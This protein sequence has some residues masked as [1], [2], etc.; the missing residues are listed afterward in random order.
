MEVKAPNAPVKII[1]KA[2][3]ELVHRRRVRV[4]AAELARMIH[5]TNKLSLLDVGCGDGTI[6]K[7]V[8]DTVPGLRVTGAEF[9]PRP[10]CAIPC[11]GFDGL[12]LPFPN[13]AFDGCMFVDV[14]HHSSD[15]LAIV[16]DARRVSRDFVLIKDHLAENVLDHAI[17]RFMDWVGNR[18]HGVVLPYSY[19]SKTQWERLYREAGLEEVMTQQELSI[20]PAPFSWVFDRHLHFVTLLAKR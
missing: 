9:A 13:E 18:P 15:P 6:A 12:T 8:S 3:H 14:L 20:Y 10:D 16:R 19:L 5:A 17:L 4:L 2:H 11:A 7:L 1:G